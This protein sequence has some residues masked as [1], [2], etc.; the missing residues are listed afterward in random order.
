MEDFENKIPSATK[1]GKTS[2]SISSIS[3]S[4]F[5]LER[6][7]ALYSKLKQ[8]KIHDP[9]A[10]YISCA[11]FRLVKMSAVFVSLTLRPPPTPP[12]KRSNSPPLGALAPTTTAEAELQ[13]NKTLL[14]LLQILAPLRQFSS[15]CV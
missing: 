1:V 7:S 15:H 6:I 4:A 10:L 14:R 2:C 12:P 3:C 5:R 13:Q 11:A 8:G 9:S